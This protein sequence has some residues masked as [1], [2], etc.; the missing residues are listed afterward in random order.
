MQELVFLKQALF[1]EI[2]KIGVNKAV[3]LSGL[4]QPDI[5]AWM[6]GKRRWSWSKILKV[7][8]RLNL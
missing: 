3:D 7:A 6:H 1:Y 8:D 5:S 2:Q 4:K